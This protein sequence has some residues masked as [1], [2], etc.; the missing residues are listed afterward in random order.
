LERRSKY[1]S[2]FL[3]F[4][5]LLIHHF[6]FSQVIRAEVDRDKILIG[7]QIQLKLTVENARMITSWFNIP[8]TINHI[9]VV[10]RNKID[11]L[12]VNDVVTYQQI[13]T[14]TSFDSGRWEFPALSVKGVNQSTPPIQ[15]DV[16][17]VDVSHL[18]DYHDIKDIEEAQAESSTAIIIILAII[19]LLSILI[20]IWLY[21]RKKVAAVEA[22][23]NISNQSPL[24]WAIAELDKLQQ[25]QFCSNSNCMT[26]EK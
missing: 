23:V 15:I 6:S 16:L 13:I 2:V 10:E 25:Q 1:K 8:D 9:E 3:L 22:P 24:E 20:L 21:R 18:Q 7:E 11:T 17:P 19:T 5:I 4:S 14:L 26:M 12:D